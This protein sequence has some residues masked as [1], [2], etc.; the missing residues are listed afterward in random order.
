MKIFSVKTS[1]CFHRKS[2]KR[3]QAGRCLQRHFRRKSYSIF[4]ENSSVFGAVY[5]DEGGEN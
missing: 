5:I 1:Q 3:W 4:A 2:V